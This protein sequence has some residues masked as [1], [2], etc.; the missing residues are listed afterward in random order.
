MSDFIGGYPILLNLQNKPVAVVGGGRVATRK[1][2]GLLASGAWPLVISPAL[3]TDLQA[4]ADEGKIRWVQAKYRRD[5]LN[6]Y[7]PVLVIAATDDERVNQTVA[8][9]AHRI[10]ALV[11]VI[12][13]SRG[14][15]DFSNMA[16]I[17]Q[18]PITIALTTHGASPA[19]LRQL[20][21]RLTEV[22]DDEY[23]ILSA[24][25][26]EIRQSLKD[27]ID[28]LEARQRVYRQIVE[29]DALSLLRSG[30]LEQARRVFQQIIFEGGL[31]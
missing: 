23:V 10:R 20:K 4:L 5:T 21:A 13:G 19:L 14:D 3:A 26:G 29:S 24:W 16:L 7:M 18:P 8:Q 11:N 30:Q 2:K 22:L 12:D 28:A 6:S 9:D 15:S 31:Q 17:H 1:V 27:D 25:L